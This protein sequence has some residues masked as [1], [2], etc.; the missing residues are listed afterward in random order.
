MNRPLRV[1]LVFVF[2]VFSRCPVFGLFFSSPPPPSHCPPSSLLFSLALLGGWP[3]FSCVFFL[4]M[5]GKL[6][7]DG[8]ICAPFFSSLSI[9]FFSLS[10]SFSFFSLNLSFSSPGLVAFFLSLSLSLYLSRTLFGMHLQRV[11][12]LERGVK[13][14]QSC[15]K[16]GSKLNPFL[17][18]DCG[19]QSLCEILPSVPLATWRSAEKCGEGRLKGR[20]QQ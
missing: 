10:I 17:W 15:W 18:Q 16:K 19:P 1:C 2:R 13:R 7:Q 12:T 6:R 3:G 8:A 9:L 5:T 4:A 11:G 20:N 14:A